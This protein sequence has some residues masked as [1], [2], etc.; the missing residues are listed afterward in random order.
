[1]KKLNLG[2]YW[3]LVL[4]IVYTPLILL[5]YISLKEGKGLVPQVILT[6]SI[7]LIFAITDGLGDYLLVVLYDLFWTGSIYFY[8]NQKKMN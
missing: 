1:L 4:L 8:L 6:I 3:L 7:A 5:K 2:P